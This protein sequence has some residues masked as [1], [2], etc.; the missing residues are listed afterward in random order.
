MLESLDLSAAVRY[1][2]YSTFGGATTGKV[3][4]RWQPIEDLVFRGTY[5]KGFRAPNLGELYG[6]TQFG[7]TLVDPCG[8]TGTRGRE[9]ADGPEHHAAGNCLPRAGRADGFE[10]ANT[11]ITTFTGGNP[12]LQPEKSDSYTVGIGARREL[13]RGLR[14]TADLRVHLLQPRDRQTAS[15]RATSRRC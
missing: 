10:Q 12:D 9:S 2:D 4:F 6:L 11:Q 14:R 5:S 7:A 15:R 13:G 1:S 8:P 3:G